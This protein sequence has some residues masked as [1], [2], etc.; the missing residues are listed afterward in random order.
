[1]G[2]G[3]LAQEHNP[4]RLPSKD[5][6]WFTNWTIPCRPH[7]LGGAGISAQQGRRGTHMRVP[8]VLGETGWR[9][10]TH[11]WG[12]LDP[13]MEQ[14]HCNESAFCHFAPAPRTGPGTENVLGPS[15]GRNSLRL[16]G[17]GG[18]SDL[19]NPDWFPW[20]P[21]SRGPL[22]QEGLGLTVAGLHFGVIL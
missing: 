3:S 2:V 12:S 9:L 10:S 6:R 13:E 8:C 5:C 4:S 11:S 7:L 17:S 20:S 19:G 16:R 22:V 21:S 1:M 18:A 15:W 14:K